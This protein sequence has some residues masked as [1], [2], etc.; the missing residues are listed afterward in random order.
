M[1]SSVPSVATVYATLRR[2]SARFRCRPQ[3]SSQVH[4]TCLGRER[5]PAR[6]LVSRNYLHSSVPSVAAVYANL[7]QQ[8]ARFRCRSPASSPSTLHVSWART[9]PCTKIRFQETRTCTVLLPASL[10]RES[11]QFLYTSLA[12]HS[13]LCASPS[14]NE[15]ERWSFKRREDERCRPLF[16]PKQTL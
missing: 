13:H 2:Q 6:S 8:S 5:A 10:V 4:C 7:R 14:W 12:G 1:H 9:S 16:T 15:A 11:V 3:A